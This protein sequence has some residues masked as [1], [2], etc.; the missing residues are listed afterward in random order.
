MKL[1][2]VNIL[3]AENG[4]ILKKIDILANDDRQAMQSVADSDDCPIC[5]V[6]SD[7]KKVGSV[8]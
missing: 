7:G 6:W 8:K 5:E 4:T 2:R 1:Y 3:S